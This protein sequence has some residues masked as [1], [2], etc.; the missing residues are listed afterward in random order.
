MCHWS[1][2]ARQSDRALRTR[3][4]RVRLRRVCGP[5]LNRSSR[6]Q[7]L[8]SCVCPRQVGSLRPSHRSHRRRGR[9]RYSLGDM[10]R[11]QKRAC[12]Q[13][14]L[15][16]SGGPRVLHFSGCR[17]NSRRQMD[18]CSN[19]SADSGL[20]ATYSERI[21][22]WAASQPSG[23][24]R[25]RLERFGVSKCSSAR[26]LSHLTC[27]PGREFCPWQA[28]GSFRVAMRLSPGRDQKSVRN[29]HSVRLR[30]LTFWLVA[31]T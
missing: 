18:L 15:P 16:A 25:L 6:H 21:Q 13:L 22:G 3:S 5:P 4:R 7:Q 19:W 2:C 23:Q 20:P 26:S 31:H 12:V 11:R 30:T 9:W 14:A 24:R 28:A 27:H 8:R 1:K 17:K 10:P 29:S